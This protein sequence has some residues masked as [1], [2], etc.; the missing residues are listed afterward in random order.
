MQDMNAQTA[1]SVA[2]RLAVLYFG[3]SVV[4]SLL[5]AVWMKSPTGSVVVAVTFGA[6]VLV[7]AALWRYAATL[8]RWILPAAAESDPAGALT[9]YELTRVGA[10]LLGLYSFSSGI[11]TAPVTFLVA[12]MVDKS[13]GRL[14]WQSVG[15]GATIEIVFGLVLLANAHRFAAWVCRRPPGFRE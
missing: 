13:D 10:A 5:V 4:P 12:T 14:T 8:A 15:A 1:L 11:S 9:P 7:A 3:I 6:A 2:L